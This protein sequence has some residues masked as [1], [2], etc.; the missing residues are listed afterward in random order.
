MGQSSQNSAFPPALALGKWVCP[1]ARKGRPTSPSSPTLRPS[2][3]AQVQSSGVA[4]MSKHWVAQS[5]SCSTLLATALDHAAVALQGIGT[6]ATPR[7]A[8]PHGG[9]SSIQW[10]RLVDHRCPIPWHGGWVDRWNC[11]HLAPQ[12]AEDR[13]LAHLVPGPVP[14]RYRAAAKP[15]GNTSPLGLLQG[16]RTDPPHYLYM[17][18]FLAELLGC[19]LPSKGTSPM[20]E[21][22]SHC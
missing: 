11:K 5:L 1:R 10:E 14:G 7:W 2:V 3:R 18:K 19:M 13:Q 17:A 20:F 9:N 4:K 16:E 12:S 6:P 15:A 8:L 22:K 21:S